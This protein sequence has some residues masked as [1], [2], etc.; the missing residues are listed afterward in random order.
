ME[1]IS[2]IAIFYSTGARTLN[3]GF[4]FINIVRRYSSRNVIIDFTVIKKR[5]TWISVDQVQNT[6]TCETYTFSDTASQ[7][8]D[9]NV[10]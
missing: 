3:C 4:T 10:L 1:L 5:F 2:L 8:C 6:H 9:L 7:D